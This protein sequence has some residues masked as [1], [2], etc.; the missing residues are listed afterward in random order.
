MIRLIAAVSKNGAIG[1]VGINALPFDYPEDLKHFRKS[2][3]NSTIIM[4]RTTFEG[5]GKPLPKRQNIVVT[6][7]QIENIETATSINQAIE[8][9][10]NENIWL[11]GGARIYEEGLN[12]AKE[13][14]LTLTPD[15]IDGELVKFPWINPLD[16]K[17]ESINQLENSDNC[18]LAIYRKI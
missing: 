15:I 16:F 2:T 13:L 3:L 4:G 14:Y 8:K 11:I 10:N 17:L 12:F 7:K 18:K 5:I 6:S 9:S 1:R